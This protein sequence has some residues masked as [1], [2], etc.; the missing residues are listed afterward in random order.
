M[1]LK[2]PPIQQSPIGAN[3]KFVQTWILWF[4]NITRIINILENNAF[5][6]ESTIKVTKASD[7]L[8]IDSTKSYLIDGSIDMGSQSIEIPE[9]GLSI[10]GLNGTR[11]ISVLY[12]SEDSYTMFTSP[13]GG[14]SGNVIMAS[15]TLDLTGTGSQVFDLDNDG[16]SGALDIVEVNFGQSPSTTLSMGHLKDY[17]QLLMD[18]T[19]FI[20]I[21]DGLTF[22][23]TWTGIRITTAIA[24]VFPAST[25][26]LIEGAS[27]TV[28]NIISD[29]NFL[30]VQPSSIFCDFSPS[31]IIDDG[32]MRLNEVRTVAT[33]ALP[34]IEG[35]SVKARF[36]D[37]VGFRNTYI[38]GEWT[39][40]SE[41]TTTISTVNTPVKMA[42]TTSYA[43]LDHSTGSSNNAITYIGSQEVEWRISGVLS[44]SGGNN[45]EIAVHIRQ[46]HDSASVYID[47]SESSPIVLNAS[48]RAEGHAVL[49]FTTMNK[50]DRIEIWLENQTDSSNITSKLNGIVGF[51][52]R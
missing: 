50:N 10:A 15:M 48:G 37:C 47:I 27:F 30:S 41:A 18:N 38:G 29:M 25:T 16:N 8:N 1:P 46:W 32:G 52:E 31:N 45:D 9:G 23:G 19:G 51:E 34:N 35:S 5:G 42:G 49:G 3:N 39:L 6:F 28:G 14:Y 17:R 33:D 11:D 43:D 4:Q 26:M 7:L 12:S 44:F 2:Q 24:I 22:D 21:D 40:T 36:R 13:S 20:F